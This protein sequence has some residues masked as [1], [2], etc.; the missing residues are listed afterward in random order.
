MAE[1]RRPR[2][3]SFDGSLSS[4]EV[5]GRMARLWFAWS[6]ALWH[7]PQRARSLVAKT[8]AR[9]T[10]ERRAGWEGL[11]R[12]SF[13]QLKALQVSRTAPGEYNRSLIPRMMPW[14]CVC[15][16]SCAISSA[17]SI[18]AHTLMRGPTSLTTTTTMPLGYPVYCGSHT[19]GVW[20]GRHSHQTAHI[21]ARALRRP[22]RRVDLGCSC[23]SRDEG[24]PVPEGSTETGGFPS[25]TCHRRHRLY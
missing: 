1:P 11:R 19:W 6:R 21:L 8:T 14:P 17:K 16:S 5:D 10:Q 23:Q 3:A 22:L 20:R 15:S 25:F 7:L 24:H 13:P 4:R 12:P 18:R 2:M 9:S